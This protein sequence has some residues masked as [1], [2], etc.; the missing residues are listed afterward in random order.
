MYS[1]PSTVTWASHTLSSTLPSSLLRASLCSKTA[2]NPVWLS[3]LEICQ[4]WTETCGNQPEFQWCCNMNDYMISQ[5]YS[6]E[7]KKFKLGKDHEMNQSV[8]FWMPEIESKIKQLHG[9]TGLWVLVI[10]VKNF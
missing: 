5:L 10:S 9:I 7:F 6:F 2:T 8:Q 1:I 4:V 3:T